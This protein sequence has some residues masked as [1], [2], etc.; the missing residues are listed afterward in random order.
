M[1]SLTIS[2]FALGL[3]LA[4]ANAQDAG[5]WAGFYG[6]VELSY[7]DGTQ[8]YDAGDDPY[9]IFGTSAGL[10]AGYLW[11]SGAWSY[12]VEMAYAKSNF[13]EYDATNEYNDYQF[14][15][16]LDLKARV[17]YAADRALVYGVLGYGFSEW[18]E[19]GTDPSDLYDVDGVLFGFGVDYLITDQMFLGTEVLRRSMDADYPSEADVTTFAIRAGM[20]F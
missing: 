19:G 20:T 10:F 11:S 15:H 9:G 18:E 7:G 2:A 5:P 6:G 1:K 14:N 16:T 4:A 13:H 8:I 17:G 12:G 3:G